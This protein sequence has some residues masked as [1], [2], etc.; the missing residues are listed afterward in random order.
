V[1]LFRRRDEPLHERLL[2]EGGIDPGPGLS[3]R[4]EPAAPQPFRPLD[5]LH[6]AQRPREWDAVVMAA[7]PGLRGDT[8]DFVV[9]E[10]GPVVMESETPRG[11]VEPLCA[12]VEAKVRRPYHVRAV[13]KSDE[14]WAVS[15][16]RIQLVELGIDGEAL[17][18]TV[19]RAE[20][21]LVVDG[22]ERADP[23]PELERRT[24]LPPEFHATASRVEGL[25]WE[26]DVVPL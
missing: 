11:S 18:L 20:R 24:D 19:T 25:R 21:R 5:E 17:S 1:S 13:R 15:A 2:R 26:L 3:F 8:L 16:R 23:L 14:L 22:E 7:A 12:A 4:G 6:G 10:D 9:L